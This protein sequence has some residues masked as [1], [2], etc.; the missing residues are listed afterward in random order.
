MKHMSSWLRERWFLVWPVT[1]AL[2][3]GTA[4]QGSRGLME[5]SETRYAECAREMLVSGNWPEPT[6]EFEPHWTKPPFTYWCMAFGM[7]LFGANAWGVRLTAVFML[8]VAVLAVVFSARRLRGAKAG[9]AAGIALAL[10]YPGVAVNMV[11]TD[12]YVLATQSVAGALFLHAANEPSPA[13]RRAWTRGM[14]AAWGLC[15]LV[16]GAPALLPLLA[17]LPWNRLQ[18]K[19]RRAPLGDAIGLGLALTLGLAWYLIVVA[20]HPELL[21]YFVG[22]EIVDRVASDLGHNRAWYKAIEV[23]GPAMLAVAGVFGL[24][25]V[26]RTLR[27]GPWRARNWREL[28]SARDERL[29]LAGWTALPLLV[30]CLSTSKLPLYVLPLTASV[31]LASGLVLARNVRWRHLRRVALVLAPLVVSIKAIGAH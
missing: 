21:G 20:R 27:A 5:T 31:A 15:F 4:F 26:E 25:A 24:W 30:F 9:C 17:I 10:G 28:W 3:V 29:L 23:Y 2:V 12:I 19:E 16:K 11:T 22:T 7:R 13:R 18:P 8:L 14:W 6:L 1:L